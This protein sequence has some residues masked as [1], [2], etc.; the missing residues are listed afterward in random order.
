MTTRYGLKLPPQYTTITDLRAVWQIADE[1]GFDHC[2][3]Y[4]HF[5]SIGDDVAGDVYEGWMLLAAMAEATSR[6]RIGC[7]VT[8]NTYRHPAVLAKMAATVDHLSG[9]RLEFGLGAAWAEVEHTMLGLEFGTVGERMDRFE[10]AC[11]VIRSLWTSNRV[12]FTGSHYQL[13]DAVSEPK[14]VQQPHPPIW[15]GGK[16]RKR[17]LRVAA[18]YA[19]VWNATGVSTREF[20]E[21]SG[22]LDEHCAA[23]GRDPA[24]IR[25]T[26]QLAVSSDV[27]ATLAEADE[28]VAAGAD[29]V[30]FTMHVRPPVPLAEQLAESLFQYR[31]G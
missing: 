3:T 8:G 22:V 6:V 9:G 24:S 27:P 4:D 23:I 10:E 12:T 16:G 13:T 7:M 31:A 30:I 11:Q 29:D 2:W 15:V 1:A 18:A 21:L 17:S 26:I 14:P 25:R 20:G 28:F 5:A 19:D